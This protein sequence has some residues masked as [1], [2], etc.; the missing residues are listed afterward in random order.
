M[1]LKDTANLIRVLKRLRDLNNTV[2]VV[3]HDDMMMR[4]ADYID[5]GPLASHLGGEIIASGN[6]KELIHQPQSLT[7]QYL[8]G[9]LSI[10]APATLRQP[11][12]FI[13]VEGAQQ[14]NLKN[15]TVACTLHKCFV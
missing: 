10:D 9:K 15:I 11:K 12:H 6:Y 5:M 13:V 3:E 14:N 2:V 4:E 7:G 1:T 8:S